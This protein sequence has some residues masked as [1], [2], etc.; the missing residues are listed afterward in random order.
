ML[1]YCRT[2]WEDEENFNCG[3]E[4][5][6]HWLVVQDTMF[7]DLKQIKNRVAFHYE[8][9]ALGDSLGCAVAILLWSLLLL[10]PLLC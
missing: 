9:F 6:R 1:R 2:L 3:D 10:Y 4:A 8:R 5:I 7:A